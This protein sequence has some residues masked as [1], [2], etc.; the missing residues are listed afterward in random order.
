MAP[1][2]SRIQQVTPEALAIHQEALI[3]D[4]HADTASLMRM[5]Y[6]LHARHRPIL[7]GAALG[8]HLD[9]PRMLQG[10]QTG[11]VFGLVTFPWRKKGLFRIALRQIQLIRKAAESSSLLWYSPDGAVL[12]Q[13][14]AEGALV[15]MPGLE[16]VHALEGNLDN[17]DILAREGLRMCGLVHFSANEAAS[18]AMGKGSD[19]NQGLTPFGRDLVARCN[20]M[21]VLVDLA[22]INRKGFLEAVRLS[23]APLVVSHSGLS[24]LHRMW[25]NIDD[26][27]IR[28]LADTG[29]CIGIIYHRNFLGGST[30]EALVRHLVHCW[31]VGGEDTPALGSDFDGLILPPKDLPDPSALPRLTQAL[32]DHQVPERVIHKML[33]GNAL[34]VFESVPQRMFESLP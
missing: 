3:I 12:R 4:L 9:L 31:N 21:G 1:R 32:L 34:R 5:G 27:Q 29:G 7:P 25:R 26:E 28:A 22:H 23:T 15:A 8:F 20:D 18:P 13:A 30:I 16:G 14:K 6:D 2:P 10:G 24:A 33:G 17:L 19:P 11:Q